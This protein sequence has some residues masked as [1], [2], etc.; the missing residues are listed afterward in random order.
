VRISRETAGNNLIIRVK[1][2]GIGIP[3]EKQRLIFS[4]FYRVEES[5]LKFQGLG[6]G[7]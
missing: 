1:D 6:I 5:S 4:K 3:L 2:N 7:L